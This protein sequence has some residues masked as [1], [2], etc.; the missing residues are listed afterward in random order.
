MNLSLSTL[1]LSAATSR[2][3]YMASSSSFLVS[4][5]E[6]VYKKQSNALNTC[7]GALLHCTKEL[8]AEDWRPGHKHA[9]VCGEPLAADLEHHIGALPGL[10][11]VAEVPVQ[12]GRGHEVGRSGGIRHRLPRA[13]LLEDEDIAADSERVV[14]DST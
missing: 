10:E 9:P 4:G 12:V 5:S 7:G 14:L 8:C 6:S 13:E 3:W 2:C 11:E 1:Y